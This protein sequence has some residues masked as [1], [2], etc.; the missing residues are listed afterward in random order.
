MY[1]RLNAF[2]QDLLKLQI[3]EPDMQF[4]RSICY[5]LLKKFLFD[6]N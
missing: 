4:Y 2:T 6:E 3:K 1:Y 5:R